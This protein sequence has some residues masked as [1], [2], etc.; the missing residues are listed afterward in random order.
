MPDKCK[1]KYKDL[2]ERYMKNARARMDRDPWESFIYGLVLTSVNNSDKHVEALKDVK[3][4]APNPKEAHTTCSFLAGTGG[5]THRQLLTGRPYL[6]SGASMYSANQVSSAI[7]RNSRP[8]A[9]EVFGA[10]GKV[11]KKNTEPS[12]GH[13]EQ[14]MKE[15]DRGQVQR[16]FYFGQDKGSDMLL[17][18]SGCQTAVMDIHMLKYNRG[19]PPGKRAVKDAAVTK[20]L[21]DIQSHSNEYALEKKKV[22]TQAD[23]CGVD[24]GVFHVSVWL[25]RIYPND[26]AG[27]EKY[28]GELIGAIKE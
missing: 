2:G 18:E 20:A 19:L 26:R 5:Q 6:E 27:A 13:L 28:L 11:M 21:R 1:L 12:W 7:C 17:L 16:H 24:R 10:K 25:E 15:C 3:R 8:T 4:A 9:F 14:S 23:T 22:E